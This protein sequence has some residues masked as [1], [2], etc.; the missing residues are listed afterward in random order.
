MRNYIFVLSLF[1]VV[2]VFP[3][4][5]HAAVVIN[6]IAWMGTTVSANAEWIELANTDSATVDL[7]G[8]HLIAAS[9]SPSI[10]LAGSIAPNGYFL[11]E[12]TSDATVPGVPADQ[13]YTGAL[14][15]SGTTLTLTDVSGNT[16]DQVVGGSNW[17]NIGGDNI[18]KD[19]AQRTSTGWETAAPT[20]R[21]ANAG[22]SSDTPDT[23]DASTT[24]SAVSS[25]PSGGAATY[26]PPPSTILVD[27]SG[28]QDA[29]LEVPLQLSARVT[30][31][32]GAADPSAQIS[33]SFGDGSSASGSVVKKIY[34]YAGTYLVIASATD[35]DATAR[36]E[37]IVIVKP[38]KVHLLPVSS[39]GVTIVNDSNGRLDLSEWK[40]LSDTGSF[41]VPD[42]TTLLPEASVLFP[43]SITNLPIAFDATLV[44]PDGAIA[45]QYTPQPATPA[46][47]VVAVQPSLATTSYEEVQ[48]IEHPVGSTN[49]SPII[50]TK[51][52]IQAHD[53]AVLAPTAAVE[54][55]AVGAASV[56]VPSL[57]DTDAAPASTTRA[58]GLFHSPWTFSLFG[59]IAA[60]GGAFILL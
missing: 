6:E 41:L 33:W 42:G 13:I 44:F 59:V 31:R 52:N 53:E 36:D 22:V 56:A 58:S 23:A 45:A 11:L 25:T 34:R 35:G 7:T 2:L 29:L 21:A 12:R 49:T 8:W 32:S 30:T 54:P 55:A 28:S 1:S 9:G 15:N 37:L 20:P 57:A 18:S 17:A 26:T 51:A 4:F 16:I 38:A 39:D 60:A 14:T 10:T 50:S 27:V 47:P 3:V 48:A 24:D 5:V 46:Q 43:F 19:T 40:I